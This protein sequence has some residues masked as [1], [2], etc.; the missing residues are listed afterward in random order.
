MEFYLE[1]KRLPFNAKN[2]TDFQSENTN[3]SLAQRRCFIIKAIIGFISLLYFFCSFFFLIIGL[4]L[5][6][7][8]QLCVS[9]CICIYVHAINFVVFV[10]LRAGFCGYVLGF[11]RLIIFIIDLISSSPIFVLHLIIWVF[12]NHDLISKKSLFSDRSSSRYSCPL[13]S[14]FSCAELQRAGGKYGFMDPEPGGPAKVRAG[15]SQC[16]R[17][18]LGWRRQVFETAWGIIFTHTNSVFPSV[19]WE[20]CILPLRLTG[21]C[22]QSFWKP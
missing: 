13:P 12:W 14:L 4:L 10:L 1:S 16:Q 18:H 21:R 7:K 15:S 2:Q 8:D 19:K 9:V 11:V 20:K 6:V 22:G 3:L 17:Q 5:E